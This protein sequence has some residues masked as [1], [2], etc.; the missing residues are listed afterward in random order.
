VAFLAYWD[1]SLSLYLV[2]VFG[3]IS[4]N[5]KIKPWLKAIALNALLCGFIFMI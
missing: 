1:L 2:S 4:H 5:E 3:I